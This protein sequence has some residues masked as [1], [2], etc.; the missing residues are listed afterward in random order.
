MIDDVEWDLFA[1]VGHSAVLGAKVHPLASVACV[2]IG[3]RVIILQGS[4]RF[5]Q[6]PWWD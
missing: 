6:F 1:Y 4:F 5:L 3:Y 2:G